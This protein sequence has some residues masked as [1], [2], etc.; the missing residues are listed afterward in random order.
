MTF[1]P[2]PP[3]N[4][5]AGSRVFSAGS[6]IGDGM[7][8]LGTNYC[9]ANPN[10]TGNT[11]SISATG[12]SSVAANNV[13]LMGSDLPLNATAFFLTSM[14]QG[15]TPN[16]GGSEGNLCLGGEIGRYVGPGQVLNTGGS[17]MASLAIDLTQT[18]TPTGLVS[19]QAGETWN[20]QCWHR[21]SN[22]GTATSNF[23]DGLEI[24]FN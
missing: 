2:A 16:P 21:D 5:V 18:P 22:M 1:D 23:T 11:G 12:S 9:M 24:M 10:S 15:F 19:V 4:A 6:Y 8:G 13:T 17:G 14:M 3:M 7:G 20:F